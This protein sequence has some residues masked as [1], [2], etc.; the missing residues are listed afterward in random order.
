[1]TKEE[2][3]KRLTQQL[4]YYAGDHESIINYQTI[5]EEML[6]EG[7]NMDEV[8]DKL[9]RPAVLADEIAEEFKLNYTTQTIKATTMPSWAK[10]VLIVIG[11]LILVPFLLSLVFGA[12]GT[13]LSLIVGII[14]F[15]FGVFDTSGFMGVSGVTPLFKGLSIATSI[16]ALISCLII[17]YFIIYWVIALIK[18]VFSKF[19][20]NR[21]G[22]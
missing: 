3:I 21:G 20:T 11:A 17:T 14:F 9:G 19:N 13:S 5:I 22:L 8:V 15:L 16:A 18:Y 1:M 2:Y 7:H 12:V 10:T 4:N 6:D